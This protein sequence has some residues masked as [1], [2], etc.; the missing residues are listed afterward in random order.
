MRDGI[1]FHNGKTLTIDDVIY[2][3]KRTKTAKLN[4]FGN[5]GF[6]AIDLKKIKKL[7]SRTARLTLSR[8]DVTLM[9]AFAQY[10]QGIVPVGY[11]PERGRQGAA[12]LHRHRAVQGQ[13][14]HAGP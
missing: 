5:A 13:E 7:D 2:S 14:L 10:F 4:L 1:E 9:E 3:I 6:G 8:P 11:Q 12:P